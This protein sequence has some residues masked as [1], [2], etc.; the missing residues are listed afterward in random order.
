MSSNS[1]RVHVSST[2]RR[3]IGTLI[4]VNHAKLLVNIRKASSANKIT[5][6]FSL[7]FRLIFTLHT[8]TPSSLK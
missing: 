6:Q 4:T 7:S 3:Y 5:S 2:T 8:N 1:Y